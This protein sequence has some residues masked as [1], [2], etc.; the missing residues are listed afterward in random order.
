VRRKTPEEKYQGRINKQDKKLEEFAIDQTEWAQ[1]LIYWYG[2]K[3]MEIPDNEYR[4]CAFFINKEYQ[5]KPGSLTLLYYMNKRC[6]EELPKVTKE[7]AFSYLAY[8]FKCYAEVLRT[9]GIS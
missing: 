7:N 6:F 2:I 8:Q 5:R 4:A 1:N 9:G 3:K